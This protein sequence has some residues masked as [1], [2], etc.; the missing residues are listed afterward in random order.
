MKPPLPW[1]RLA[2]DSAPQAN[3]SPSG[4]PGVALPTAGGPGMPA[5]A[6]Q[7]WCLLG[8]LRAGYTFFPRPRPARARTRSFPGIVPAATR[9]W[10]R[11]T[12]YAIQMISYSNY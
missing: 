6:V 4:W 11:S 5:A 3:T 7:T 8:G 9:G 1:R 10:P 12:L 2:T